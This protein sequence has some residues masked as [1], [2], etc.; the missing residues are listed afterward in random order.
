MSGQFLQATRIGCFARQALEVISVGKV[1][2]ATSKGVFLL[3]GKYS[4]FLTR[5]QGASPFNI[6][7]DENTALPEGLE[8]NDEVFFSLDDLLIPARRVTLSLHEASTWTPPLPLP[9]LNSPEEQHSRLHE[10]VTE[11]RHISEEKGFL[12]LSKEAF[13]LSAQQAEVKT[14]TDGFVAA[15]QQGDLAACLK[16]AG[17][18]FGRGGGLTPSA[19]DWLTGFLLFQVRVR[20]FDESKRA[21]I[22]EVGRQLTDLAYA[23]TTFVSANRLEATCQGWSED[24]FL[25]VVDYAAGKRNEG[26]PLLVQ[27]LFD[28]GHS[29]GVDTLMGLLAAANVAEK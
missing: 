16:A 27:A 11:I 10:L 14:L 18:L 2:G 21:F 15:F 20:A 23:R 29:S 1:M 24:L 7:V 25:R 19:D 28:F 26:I 5:A 9:A 6:V 12:F 8:L 4:L 22:Y 3:F 13:L 17:Q